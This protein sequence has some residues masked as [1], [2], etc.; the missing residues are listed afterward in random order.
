MPRSFLPST[1]AALLAW[2]RN[3]SLRISA[4]PTAYGLTAAQATSYAAANTAYANAYDAAV[5][6]ITRTRGKIAAKD[7][8]R[9][10]VEAAARMLARYVQADPNVTNEQ[11]IDLGLTVRKSDL[12]PVPPPAMSP[13]IDFVSVTGRTVRIRL[14]EASAARRGKPAGVKGATVFSHVGQAPPGD[15]S[16]WKFEANTSK[17][18]LDVAFPDT[19]PAGSLVWLT[20][21][22]FNTKSESGPACAPVSTNI[23]GGG[24]SMAA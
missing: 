4:T 19:A 1:D 5:D 6:P 12:T 9:K 11:K 2:S 13:D 22:W 23:A 20:A 14:H 8:A 10:A 21:F 16:A 7:D 18:I 17:T 15:I 24:V 3:F